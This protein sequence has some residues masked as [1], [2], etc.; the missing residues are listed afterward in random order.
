VFDHEETIKQPEDD[1]GNGKEIKRDDHFPMV[2]QKRKPAFRRVSTT[3]H[4]SQVLRHRSFGY[5]KAELLNFAVDSRR[6]P[7]PGSRPA[8]V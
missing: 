4:P 5:D 3:V 7:A 1:G 8:C 2:A 6:P